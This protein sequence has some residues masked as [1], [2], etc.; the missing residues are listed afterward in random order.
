VSE[1]WGGGKFDVLFFVTIFV[2]VLGLAYRSQRHETDDDDDEELPDE[3]FENIVVIVQTPDSRGKRSEPRDR[4]GVPNPKAKSEFSGH[5]HDELNDYNQGVSQPLASFSLCFLGAAGYRTNG[6]PF[7]S[8][9]L[10][11]LAVGQ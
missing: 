11:R 1:K 7:A 2:S 4:T 9:S 10:T 6:L 8:S 5:I 3:E